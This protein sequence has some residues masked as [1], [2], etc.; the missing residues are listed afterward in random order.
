MIIVF[1][2]GIES[3]KVAYKKKFSYKIK[4]EGP[5]HLNENL[6]AD[7]GDYKP[8]EDVF[9]HFDDQLDVPH[10]IHNKIEWEIRLGD[11]IKGELNKS[12]KTPDIILSNFFLLLQK[13][14]T[15]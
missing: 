11:K 5:H 1:S 9:N 13:L 3:G 4:H 2:S 10:N 12:S 7:F 6:I 15:F 8:N 14:V